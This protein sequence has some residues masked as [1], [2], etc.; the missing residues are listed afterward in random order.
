MNLKLQKKLETLPHS[1]G[2]YRFKD[3]NGT[4]LYIGKAI[5]LY[6]RVH[7]YFRNDLDDRPW[8]RQMVP[9]IEDLEVIEAG[10]EIEALVLESAL[11]KKYEPKYNSDLKDGKSYAWIY[12]STKDKFPTVKIVRALNAKEYK[13]GELFGPY[14]SGLAVKRVF[15][16]LRKLYPFC[17]CCKEGSKESLYYYLG[18]CPGPYQGH[19]T[20]EG[21]RKNI[22][23]IIKFL[24]GRKK[25]QIEDL[26]KQMRR[27][28]KE[29]KYEKA[30]VL[31]DKINDL[32][33]LGE[34]IGFSYFDTEEEYTQKRKNT[35]KKNFD[36]LRTELGLA[37]LNRIECYDISNIQGK[38]AY[39]S[40]VVAQDGEIRR[41]EYRIF[42]IRSLN[43]PNDPA[44]LT[45]V[46]QRRF[47]NTDFNILPDIVLIDGGKSQLG[48]VRKVIPSGIFILGIS[49]GK[50]HK[51]HGGRLI[52]EFWG[53]FEGDVRQLDIQN[54][55]ILIDLRDEAHR[56]AITH[57]RKARSKDSQRSTLESIPGVGVER[58][59]ILMKTFGSIENIKKANKE[60]LNKA[61]KNNKTA[62]EV[63]KYFNIS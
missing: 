58:R 30:S 2:V 12:I 52:D 9:L 16:Y 11:I 5:N 60:E 38:E 20:E 3:K 4:I 15:T 8:V 42:K 53:L 13:N 45:E 43:T 59:K 27:Y 62:E 31:R 33:Y 26:E 41:N 7:S 51:R 40:M 63:A 28:S 48:V 46:L 47:S 32:K 17:N 34:K 55:S 21:Y 24:K 25:G 61:L 37:K 44:M 10:N 14:P 18:L 39:G 1:P 29:K 54:N 36:G 6:N 49:K 57:H 56:F 22:N 50:R 35:L 23:E 19:I